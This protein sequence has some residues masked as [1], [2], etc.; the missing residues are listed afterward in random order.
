VQCWFDPETPALPLRRSDDWVPAAAR[1]ADCI[2]PYARYGVPEMHNSTGLEEFARAHQYTIVSLAAIGSIL[3]AFAT[4]AAVMVSLYLARRNETVRIKVLLGVGLTKTA[5]SLQ[6]VTLQIENVS[7]RVASLAPQFFEW[8]LPFRRKH[9]PE[10]MF[11]V[12]N[13]SY[14]INTEPDIDVSSRV[15]V[16]T[17]EK[18]DFFRHLSNQI[19]LIAKKLTWFRKAR[20]KRIGAA[21]YA[22][23]D[24]RFK[25]KFS[26]IVADEIR[27]IVS[28][29]LRENS[30]R[31][32]RLS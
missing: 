25:V 1:M 18:D 20:L 14:L 16:F 22:N 26:R 32:N 11:N 30:I 6:C 8:R 9:Q 23:G 7:I 31:R 3:A 10:L 27:A 12:I 24:R 19:P 17:M 21:I 29:Y 15:N 28:V 5:P 2:R 13:T 4:V